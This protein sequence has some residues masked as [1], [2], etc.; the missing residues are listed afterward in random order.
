M[1]GLVSIITPV[2]NSEKYLSETIQSVLNQTYV[3]WELILVDDCSTDTSFEIAKT[4]ERK[5][6]R[7]KIYQLT[8]N[9]GA[10]IARNFGI[11]KAKG[12]LI[13]FLDADDL[14]MPEKLQKQIS[15][16][17]DKK[18]YVSYSSYRLMDEDGTLQPK[19]VHAL[20]ELT[21][22]KLLKSN[23]IG[24]LTGMYNAE[25]LGKIYSP[26]IRKRQD[27]ALWL[28]ALKTEKR[29]LGMQ[30]PLAYYRLRKGSV[31]KNKIGLLKYNYAVYREVMGFSFLKSLFMTGVFLW[32]HFF[33]KSRQIKNIGKS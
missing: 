28:A 29:A 6:A 26:A 13:A 27:W 1:Y 8:E 3:Y 30:E 18:C 16:M 22:K 32:E 23:Y 11:K 19:I 4:F 9:K 25:V 12:R 7:I 21:F 33:V 31:S 5:D 17:V 20:S 2:F 10:G 24:N 15:F 14:W